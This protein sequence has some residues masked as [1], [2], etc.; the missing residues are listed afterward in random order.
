M[1]RIIEVKPLQD[2]KVW[3][4]FSDGVEGTVDLSDIAGKGVFSSWNNPEIFKSVFVDPNTHTIAWPG[5][6]DLCP[7]SLYA[8]ITGIAITSQLT[9]A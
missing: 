9:H 5:G 3:I 2:F 7:D 6:I 4:K 8:E 1:H